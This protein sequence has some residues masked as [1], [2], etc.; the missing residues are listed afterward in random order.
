MQIFNFKSAMIKSALAATVLLS[1]SGAA[2]AQQ[3]IN[4]TAAP[5]NAALSDGSLVPMWGYSCGTAVTGSTAVC[6][7]LNPNALTN[8]TPVVI[9]VPTGQ[10][11]Q[12]NL[13]NNLT[14]GTNSVPTSPRSMSVT[15][16]TRFVP[17]DPKTNGPLVGC[18]S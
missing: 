6:A 9:T 3:V 17:V 15:V 7:A 14:F 16:D 13:T 8:W 11:L 4:L 12:I 18:P 10:D 1:A 5:A 2:L